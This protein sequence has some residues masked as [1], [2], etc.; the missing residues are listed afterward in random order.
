MKQWNWRWEVRGHRWWGARVDW[1]TSTVVCIVGDTRR[2][3]VRWHDRAAKRIA[4]MSCKL[5][6][7]E[8]VLWNMCSEMY[9]GFYEWIT[10]HNVCYATHFAG[11]MSY[12]MICGMLCSATH[13]VWHTMHSQ[14]ANHIKF[15]QIL[16]KS[17]NTLYIYFK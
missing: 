3:R 15:L 1:S 10:E 4:R 13:L 6:W 11:N 17:K 16:Y 8:V 5:G 7:V 2:V 12:K 9:F 14:I